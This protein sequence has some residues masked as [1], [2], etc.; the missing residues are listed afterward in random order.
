MMKKVAIIHGTKGSS[1]GNWFPWLAAELTTLGAEVIVPQM[2]TP[3]GQSLQNWLLSFQEQ[4]GLLDATTT[5]VGHSLGAVFLLRL[6]E[7]LQSPIRGSVFVAA[8]TGRIGIAEYDALNSSFTSDPYNWRSIRANAGHTLCLSGDN[9]PYVPLAQGLEIS[10]NLGITPLVIEG[11][12][13]LNAESG[14]AT[15]PLLLEALR[16]IL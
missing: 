12:G 1:K 16:Q 9:D 3:E 4:V 7:R 2:P 8:F 15:F 6:L 5:V 10:R 11:G 13:H 14:Y